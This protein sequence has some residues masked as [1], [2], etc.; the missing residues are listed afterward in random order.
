MI[1]TSAAL[2]YAVEHG[3]TVVEENVDVPRAEGDPAAGQE[4]VRLVQIRV[5][6]NDEQGKVI[7][8]TAYFSAEPQDAPG[9]PQSK[10]A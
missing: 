9:V 4:Q 2:E 10:S 3:A 6:V 1:T 7:T 8:F 5:A